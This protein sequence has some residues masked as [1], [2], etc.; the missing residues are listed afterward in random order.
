MVSL[1]CGVSASEGMSSSPKGIYDEIRVVVLM[2]ALRARAPVGEVRLFVCHGVDHA[3]VFDGLTNHLLRCKNKDSV[4][5]DQFGTRQK[6]WSP[7]SERSIKVGGRVTD[8]FATPKEIHH[9][10][11]A[12]IGQ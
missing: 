9:G 4:V 10:V 8:M 2:C 3:L 12:D 5:A 1:S 6:S 7:F 11:D